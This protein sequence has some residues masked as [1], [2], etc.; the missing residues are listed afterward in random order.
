M[1]DTTH[2]FTALAALFLCALIGGRLA[3]RIHVPR[4]TGYLIAGLLA[5]PSLAHLL[6]MPALL[7]AEDLAT[8]RILAE[9][10]LSLILAN[11]GTQFN[12]TQLRRWGRQILLFSLGDVGTTFC[13]V[14]GATSLTNLLALRLQV[15]DFSLTETS[16]LFGLILAVVSTTTAPAATL[17][18][19]R[20]YESEGPV[21]NSVMTLIG[22][23]NL[24]TLIG[25]VILSH[26]LSG[27]GQPLDLAIHLAG[28]LVLGLLLGLILSFW[29]QRLD[30][31]SE[32][33][34][35]L[36]GGVCLVTALCRQ[37]GLDPLLAAFAM[38]MTLANACPGWH[39]LSSSLKQIDYPLYVV[40]F[41]IAG[42]NLHLET[43]A[44]IGFLGA[45]Y[46]VARSCGKF[47]GPR[48]G[49]MLGR[50]GEQERKWVSYT[51]LA[52]GGVAIGL[53]GALKEQ[54]PEG[55]HLL[56]AVILGSVVIFEFI[57]PLAVRYGLIRAGEVPLLNIL[58]KR[59]PQG[60]MEGLHSVVLHFRTALGLP[61]GHKVEHPGDI[62]VRHIMRQNV[63]TARN[64]MRFNELLKFISHS[65]YDR[66]PVQDRN[67]DFV[68][69]IDYTEIRSLLFD[70]GLSMLVVA[71]DLVSGTPLDLTPDM[72]LRD[73]LSVMQKHRN[74]SF[75]PV[76]DAR[77]PKRL[78]GILRQND[79]LAAFRRFEDA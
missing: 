25:F 75:F 18:V 40:F 19:I 58:T 68:G 62:L 14:F 67:G 39:K 34:L 53:S 47:F 28:P 59:A 8:L 20:E 21:T 48:I 7:R 74:I 66:F 78:L 64:D 13:L 37:L 72:T 2:L 52:Q 23:N 41:V 16:L 63:E 11:I 61:A 15:A 57:G 36:M 70:S 69:M 71:G 42:A 54:W 50:M 30:L 1:P 12:L 10:T 44:H 43:L 3:A 55:G 27:T 24:I 49:A 51:L 77:N 38:G 32:H 9:V 65:R 29:G 17:M 46:V 22:L 33:K 60:A 73:C 31:P 45:A 6:G 56:E 26:F 79:V 76:V 4:V 35:M 5:G